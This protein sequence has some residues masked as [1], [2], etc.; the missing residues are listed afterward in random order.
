[1]AIFKEQLNTEILPPVLNEMN[2]QKK[3]TNQEH[4]SYVRNVINQLSL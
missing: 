2:L 4:C 3:Y 1:M